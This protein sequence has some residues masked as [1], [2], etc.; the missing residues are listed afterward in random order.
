MNYDFRKNWMDIVLPLIQLPVMKKAIKR[1][2]TLFIRAGHG[3]RDAKFVA[4]KPPASYVRNDSW[5]THLLEYEEALSQRLIETGALLPPDPCVDEDDEDDETYFMYREEVLTP[6]IDYYSRTSLESFRMYSACHWW[7]PT[8]GLTLAKLVYPKEEWRC[9][10]SAAHTTVVNADES[11]VFDILY[12][13]E[14][15]PTKG[16]AAAIERS[17]PGATEISRVANRI[18]C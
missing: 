15:D 11:L 10:K 12:F 18:E 4:N 17:A 5:A 2:I 3:W 6:F 8:F 7:N 14:N 9:R 13:D 1:G 16:G